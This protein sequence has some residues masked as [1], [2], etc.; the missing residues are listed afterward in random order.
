MQ[1]TS[2]RSIVEN[3]SVLFIAQLIT[4]VLAL[5][6][7][8]FLPRYLGV[9]ALGKYQLASS[10]WAIMIILTTLGMDTLLTKEVSRSPERTADLFYSSVFLRSVFFILGFSLLAAYSRFAG[11]PEDTRHVIYI[12]G[13]ANFF[14]QLTSCCQATLQGLERMESIS[15]SDIFSKTF[16]TFVSIPLLLMGAGVLLI[17]VVMVGGAIISFTYQYGALRKLQPMKWQLKA[18]VL[19]WM[20]KASAPFLLIVGIRTIYSQLDVVILSLLAGDAVTGWYGAASRLFGTLMFIPA[21]LN[22]A[23]FP[24]MARMHSSES[25]RLPTLFRKNF[26][27]M[28][29]VAVPIGLGTFLIANNLVVLLFGEGFR[30]SGPVLALLGVVLIMTY[31]NFILGQYLISTDRHKYWIWLSA[32]AMLM[33]VPLDLIFIPWCQRVFQNG[34]MGGSFSFLITEAVILV[35][36]VLLLPKGLLNRST[37]QYA[38]RIFLAG[39]LMLAATWWARD[40][41]I[42][43]PAAIGFVS[44]GTLAFVMK[45]VPREDLALMRSVVVSFL[46]RLRRI[47]SEVPGLGGQ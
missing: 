46:H 13:A 25:E 19:G 30:N 27:V 9:V 7:S 24:V 34:A 41:F 38:L 15:L 8:I 43:T 21:V 36:G 35:V 45:L 44:Y 12:I 1:T 14:V 4:W 39:S 5:L 26:D 31:Q 20:I 6:L 23:V 33:T 2:R 17:S 18:D 40:Y 32:V 28:L 29:L 3:A 16:I 42:L 22:A 47:K 37:W 10:L 11:Y